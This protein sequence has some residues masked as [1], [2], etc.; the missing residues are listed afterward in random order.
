MKVAQVVFQHADCPGLP[1][2]SD[3]HFGLVTD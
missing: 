2:I 3:P 1:P